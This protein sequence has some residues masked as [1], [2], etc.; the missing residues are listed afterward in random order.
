LVFVV[1]ICNFERLILNADISIIIKT[2]FPN[3]IF[4]WD[5]NLITL[6]TKISRFRVRFYAGA[7][8]DSFFY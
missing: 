6:Y 2:I 4:M 3:D 5:I 1:D 8:L 7:K